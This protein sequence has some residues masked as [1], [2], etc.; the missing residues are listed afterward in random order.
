VLE[1][2]RWPFFIVAVVLSAVVV[3]IETGSAI[4]AQFGV[5]N[6]VGLGIPY[7][8]LVDGLLFYTI[9]LMV[10]ALIM[11]ERLHGTLQG[12]VTFIVSLLTLLASL[13]MLFAAILALMLMVTLL[14]AVPFGTIAYFA[15]FGHFSRGTAQVL[16]SLIMTCKL[17]FIGFLVA[18]QQRFLE[19]KI[20]V[21]TVIC[22]LLITFV[23][24][25]LQ[26]LVPVPLDSILDAVAAI[27]VAIVGLILALILLLR[28]I[29]AVVKAIV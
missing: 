23:T 19:M 27:V 3:L 12:I 18:A 29:P 1:D 25:F 9:L 11:P 4:V 28:S 15:L 24:A 7:S 17:F 10:L 2:L 21:F 6:P 5:N 26:G 20:L 22:A 16:L 13:A 8:V 14:L